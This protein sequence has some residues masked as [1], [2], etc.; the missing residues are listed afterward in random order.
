MQ[1]AALDVKK[2]HIL[3][4]DPAEDVLECVGRFIEESGVRQA[5]VVGAYGTLAAH[6]LHWVMHNQLPADNTFSTGEGGIEILSMNGLIVEGVPHIHVTLSTLGG[7]Y[8]GHLEPGCITYV[9][10][11]IFIAEVSGVALRRVH[12]Q[13]DVPDMGKGEVPKLEFGA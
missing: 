8:G 6:S 7:A 13:V 1:W 3:R 9:L 2:M 12:E 11:E 10:C 4:V 5:I